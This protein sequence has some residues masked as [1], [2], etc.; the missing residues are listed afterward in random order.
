M[1]FFSHVLIAKGLYRFLSEEVVVDRKAFIYGNVKPD[2]PTHK[3][4]HHTLDKYL[5]TVNSYSEELMDDEVAVREFSVRL[6]E[7]CHYVCDFFCYYHLEEEIHNK[8]LRHFL[9]ELKLHHQLKHD[10]KRNKIK[11]ESSGLEPKKDI[12]YI[13]SEMRRN[14]FEQPCMINRDIEYAFLTTVRICE[15][16]IFYMEYSADLASMAERAIGNV[17]VP[18]GGNV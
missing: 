10:W 5:D 2:L 3:H 1:Y 12:G 6:G 7:I 4:G 16:I 8:R 11:V 13:I 18:E 17:L 15:S 9:Y 14:Y